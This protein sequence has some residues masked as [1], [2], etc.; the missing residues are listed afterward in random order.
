MDYIYYYYAL[1]LLIRYISNVLIACYAC[2]IGGLVG[3]A[4]N[5]SAMKINEFRTH[6]VNNRKWLRVVEVLILHPALISGFSLTFPSSAGPF[7]DLSHVD[8]LLLD[9]SLHQD[10]PVHSSPP[11]SSRAALSLLTWRD[12]LRPL[13]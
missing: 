12:A 3:A 10:L 1:V 5:Y 11:F 9:P 6:Y 4:F 2:E 13:V 7:H 8:R